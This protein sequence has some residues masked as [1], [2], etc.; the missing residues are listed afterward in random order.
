MQYVEN[1]SQ[2]LPVEG[3]QMILNTPTC[4]SVSDVEKEVIAFI[5]FIAFSKK[6][7]LEAK[8]IGTALLRF[9]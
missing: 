3:S 7:K 2:I 9:A 4:S 6:R 5:S 8:D 1:T